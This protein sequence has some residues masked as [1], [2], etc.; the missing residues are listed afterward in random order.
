MPDAAIFDLGPAIGEVFLVCVATA[1]LMVGAFRSQE[2]A[3]SRLVM[4]LAV[5]ALVADMKDKEIADLGNTALKNTL[6]ELARTIL[7]NR[8]SVGFGR[9]NTLIMPLPNDALHSL[10]FCHERHPEFL[11]I[12]LIIVKPVDGFVSELDLHLRLIAERLNLLVAALSACI[13]A[14]HTQ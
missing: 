11:V 7:K 8:Q 3:A 10:P 4:P 13:L 9:D 14:E 6:S 2:P 12:H 1:L 5:M